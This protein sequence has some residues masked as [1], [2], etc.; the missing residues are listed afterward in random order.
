MADPFWWYLGMQGVALLGAPLCAAT[1]WRL[2]DRGYGFSKAFS[3]IILTYLFWILN[4]AHAVPNS[5]VGVFAVAAALGVGSLAVLA[6]NRRTA[7]DYVREQLGYIIAIEVLVAVAFAAMALLRVNSGQIIFGEKGMDFMYLN[8]VFR[9]DYFPPQDPWFAGHTVAYY[10][11]GF[12][13]VEVLAHLTGTPPQIAFTLAFASLG[14]MMVSAAAGLA[15]NVLQLARG[16]G[17]AMTWPAIRVPV[18]AKAVGAALVFA[19]AGNLIGSLVWASSY[20]IGSEGFY[21]WLNIQYLEGKEPRHSWY[22]SL[23]AGF[24]AAIAPFTNGTSVV[25]LETPVTSMIIGDLH[26][27]IVAVPYTLLGLAAVLVLLCWRAETSWRSFAL[28]FPLGVLLGAPGAV[29]TF[30][31]V[32]LWPVAA[33]AVALNLW[34]HGG[35]LAER[36]AAAQ[37]PVLALVLALVLY[38]PFYLSTG[39]R[40][41]GVYPVVQNDNVR[42]PATRWLHFLLHWGWLFFICGSFVAARIVRRRDAVRWRAV[43]AC[44]AVPIAIVA[45]WALLFAAQMAGGVSRLDAATGLLDQ[46][47]AREGAWFSALVAGALLAAALVA[48]L[49][50]EAAGDGE[51]ER[52]PAFVLL[53]TAAGAAVV[54]GVEFFYVADRDNTRFLA[55]FKFS[56]GAWTLLAVAAGSALF[57]LPGELAR[58]A[59]RLRPAWCAAAGLLLALGL[60]IPL[61]MVPGRVRPYLADGTPFREPRSFDATALYDPDDHA[62]IEWLRDQGGGQDRTMVESVVDVDGRHDYS[63]AGRISGATGVPVVLGWRRHEEQWRPREADEVTARLVV[64]DRLYRTTDMAEAADI[65]ELYEID[66]VYVG[67]I[68]RTVYGEAAIA[69]F[70]A[71]PV[72]YQ[73]GAAVIYDVSSSP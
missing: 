1:F 46:V 42:L 3:F 10:Y 12:V 47:A 60:F 67:T 36:W 58:A 62:A 33:G 41:L 38:A 70:A 13:G 43:A 61:G 25:A 72:R 56:F 69:K 66:D 59:P 6:R 54:L 15:C 26:S 7:L 30:D 20:G 68:E 14:A 16:A 9:A 48:L 52:G 45:G 17:G 64:V 24:S 44:V 21:D 35:T 50:E 55:Q 22:P 51:E 37:A 2:P 73:H 19:L 57:L 27:H 63:R 4:V 28:A 31:V 8:A 71:Y 32:W 53:L 23:I 49:L 5:R 65:I 18:A 11:L 29:N 39:G 34:R 40:D